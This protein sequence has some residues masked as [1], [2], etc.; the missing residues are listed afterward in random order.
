MTP[1]LSAPSKDCCSDAVPVIFSKSL[2]ASLALQASALKELCVIPAPIVGDSSSGLLPCH[3]QQN[4][5]QH[6]WHGKA[7]AA[8]GPQHK[9]HPGCSCPSCFPLRW[10]EVLGSAHSA[11]LRKHCIWCQMGLYRITSSALCS[12]YFKQTWEGSGL[13]PCLFLKELM[14]DSESSSIHLPY[15]DKKFW[16]NTAKCAVIYHSGGGIV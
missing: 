11:L 6:V 13:D 2:L 9:A 8:L 7:Q 16:L 12:V 1:A 10:P 3:T 4:L 14:R 15:G 5:T